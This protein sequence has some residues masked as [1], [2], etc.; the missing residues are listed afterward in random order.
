VVRKAWE[1]GL[2][3]VLMQT[4]VQLDGDVVTRM[5]PDVAQ[6]LYPD[7]NDLHLEGVTKGISVW[8]LL[9]DVIDRIARI[10]SR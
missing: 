8:T 7:L 4:I 6:G 9:L 1:L 5:T 10:V 3:Q 2:E